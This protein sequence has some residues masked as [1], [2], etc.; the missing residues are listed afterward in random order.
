MILD[1]K[2]QRRQLS[3]W[4]IGVIAAGIFI[5]LGVRY[6][7]AIAY[8]VAWAVDL[9]QPLLVGL[10]LAL[11]LNVP[12]R[13]IEPHLFK[14]HLTPKREKIRRPL[15]IILSLMLVLGIFT[16]VA[17]LV[18]PELINAVSIMI[19]TIM[20]GLNQMTVLESTVDFSKLP[21]GEQLSQIDIDWRQIE[22]NLDE[23]IKEMG[24]SVMNTAASTLGTI[25]SSI[26]DGIIGLVFA[27]YI[28]ANK[29]ELKRQVSRLIHVWLPEKFGEWIIHVSSVCNNT[30]R[31]FIA[32]QTIEAIIL[33]SLCLI[34]MLIF[35]IPYAPM[36]SALVG[37]MALIPYVGAWVA[38]I[39]GVFMILT[40]NPFKAV[41]FIIF[42]LSLQQVE[43]NLI[44]PKVVGAKMNLPPMWVL[45][46][47]TVGGNLAGPI[48][49]LL[50]V[51]AASAV[52]ALLKEATDNR[53]SQ[54][55]ISQPPYRR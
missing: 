13:V 25:T 14:K 52:Y 10:I 34:G 12:L 22:V 15:A 28:M 45:A 50:G 53:E 33:G 54:M 2:N 8:A 31:M 32:G 11:I 55:G 29:E 7:S 51:P 46:A 42:L 39:I 20:D 1:D 17:V 16:G 4:I 27:I 9:I 26:M 47:I 43:G 37:V 21:F 3:R 30:F 23:W 41:V 40:V 6:V 38:A 19:S 36:I 24:T 44:Y 35:R 48:G 49:M 5:F 18:V